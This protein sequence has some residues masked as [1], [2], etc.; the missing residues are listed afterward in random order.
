[1]STRRPA[2]RRPT[3]AGGLL[4]VIPL[5]PAATI[6]LYD[7]LY[8]G[9]RERIT[10]GLL[11]PGTRLASTR[12]FAVDL[13]VSRFTVVTAF[14]SLIAEGYVTT[15]HG[16]G[17]FVARTLPE[18]MMR[19][20]PPQRPVQAKAARPA[21]SA[22]VNPPALS[23]RGQALSAVVIT[24]PRNRTG[25]P[26]P[27]RPRRPPL[28]C[29]PFALWAR[30]VRR[31]WRTFQYELL[32]Y[33]DPAGYRPLRESIAA[34]VE[35]TR[36]VR[37]AADQVIVT[38]GAQQ[39]FDLLS[40]L[41]LDPGD[42]VWIEEPGYLDLRGALVAAGARLV[43]VPV[44]ENGLDVDAGIR[45]A[46]DARVICVSPS[47][48]YPI[49]ATLSASRRFALLAWAERAGAWIIEDDYDSYFRYRGHPLPALQTLDAQRHRPTGSVTRQAATHAERVVYVGTFSK[50]MFPSLR[51]GYCVVPDSLIDAVVNARAVADRNS[52]VV[53][54]AALAAFID[55][56]HYDRHL[57]RVRAACVERYEAICHHV[58]RS[59]AGGV[60]LA[61]ANA[62]THVVG[63]LTRGARTDSPV[64]GR[65]SHAA[66]E[67][68]M[69]IFP[70]SRYFIGPP[71]DNG[72]VLGYG[73]L[74]PA[75]IASGVRRLARVL[76][77]VGVR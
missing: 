60:R 31:Q 20:R 55:A 15:T 22:L 58:A 18:Q 37:C 53:D 57:R 34:H 69:V 16:G 5:D 50:T 63:W 74:P 17:T 51:L 32:D 76:E 65:V 61:P 6:P 23:A 11:A 13:G 21:R 45:L 9:L 7:Q 27:F 2:A 28:E 66:A 25:E 10:E 41:L 49:G 3:R 14:A 35:A 71:P 36:G 26:R 56:G 44:D 43:P 33:G 72:I 54:Q 19:V 30:I 47:H 70:L 29:F 48:Q 40:R 77:R 68:G 4:P 24:G 42:P 39:A 1:V 75:L 12:A 8:T 62:G 59:L 38:S 64:D 52:P 46:P 67:D 73:G